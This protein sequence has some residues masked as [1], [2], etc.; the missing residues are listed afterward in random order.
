[1]VKKKWIFVSIAV[2]VVLIAGVMVGPIMSNV[3]KPDYTVV[4][5]EENFE[6][7][8]YP[9]VLAAEVTV[10]GAREDAIGDGFKLLADFI[11]G[12]NT[13]KTEIAMT[14]PVEQQN[15]QE[16]TTS[17]NI[18]M[19]APV[20]QEAADGSKGSWTVRFIM[21]SKYT[22]QTLPKPNNDKVKIKQIPAKKVAAI[23]FSGR[24]TD[25]NLK[26]HEKQLAKYLEQQN[27]TPK[28]HPTYAFYNPPWILPPMRRNEVMVEVEWD[29]DTSLGW[30]RYSTPRHHTA[31]PCDPGGAHNASLMCWT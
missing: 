23:R 12:N 17:E 18:A 5:Q 28:S 7:R 29:P 27:L 10:Q 30:L 1:M 26:K 4:K 19:T 22:K 2:V 13:K 31:S 6:V 15:Q 9:P 11:F 8:K 16:A 21:P 3:E 25:A 20:E 14:A 24:N